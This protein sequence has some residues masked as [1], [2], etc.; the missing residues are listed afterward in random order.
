MKAR[1]PVRPSRSHSSVWK[2]EYPAQDPS[3]QGGTKHSPLAVSN[4]INGSSDTWP[5]L[6]SNCFFNLAKLDTMA[7]DFHLAA[8]FFSTYIVECPVSIPAHQIAGFVN[9]PI[10]GGTR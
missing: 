7:A 4:E 2:G 8:A 10:A 1:P 3:Y 9:H 6:Q 5:Q